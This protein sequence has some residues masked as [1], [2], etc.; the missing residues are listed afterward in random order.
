MSNLAESL[1]LIAIMIEPVMTETA[2]KMFE[3]LGN[4]DDEDQ[5]GLSFGDF[6]W[7]TR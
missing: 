7:D 4:W 5:R 2:P 6:A 1:R 3:Q